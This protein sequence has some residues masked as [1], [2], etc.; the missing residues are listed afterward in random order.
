MPD[1][2]D[3]NATVVTAEEF[4][5]HLTEALD[6]LSREL[7][8]SLVVVLP[9]ADPAFVTSA[10]HRPLAC[11]IASGV[12]CPCAERDR[13][14]TREGAVR[15]REEAEELVNSGRYDTYS[16]FAVVLSPALSELSLPAS[17]ASSPVLKAL[18]ARWPDL[19]YL[20]PN[21]LYPSQ[22]LHALGKP[23]IL[24]VDLAIIVNYYIGTY[25]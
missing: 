11:R 24:L 13:E 21:C 6:L 25:M 12:F 3:A 1:S 19:S 15:F 7:P 20:A 22:K 18:G 2:N 16:D 4:S 23:S 9:P 5:L 8:N 10:F 17:L 14:A